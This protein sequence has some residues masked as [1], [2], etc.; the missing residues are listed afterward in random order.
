MELCEDL[1]D[2][3]QLY[4]I[5]NYLDEESAKKKLEKNWK[6]KMQINS[7]AAQGYFSQAA[8]YLCEHVSS[9]L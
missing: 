1:L 9:I 5:S 3:V 7:K 8:S 4:G 6:L 2:R